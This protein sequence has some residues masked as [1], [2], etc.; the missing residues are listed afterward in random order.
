[1]L[2]PLKSGGAYHAKR[3][4]EKRFVKAGNG[5]KWSK[6]QYVIRQAVEHSVHPTCGDSAPQEALSTP[7]ADTPAGHLSTPPT[8]G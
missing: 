8:S 5:L 4:R 1:M 7:E 6:K 2:K 3:L